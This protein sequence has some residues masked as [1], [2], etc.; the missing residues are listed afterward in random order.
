MAVNG[1]N[2][3]TT[4]V[5]RRFRFSHHSDLDAVVAVLVAAAGDVRDVDGA[6]T[7]GA[8]L[9][10]EVCGRGGVASGNVEFLDYGV[11]NAFGSPD[12]AC[13]GNHGHDEEHEFGEAVPDELSVHVFE[14]NATRHASLNVNLLDA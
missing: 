11:S 6:L 9:S 12:D 14:A 8:G 1:G 3:G 10:V 4:D 2:T 7:D 13:D 5:T